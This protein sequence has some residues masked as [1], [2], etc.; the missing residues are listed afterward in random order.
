MLN[1]QDTR[2]S[3][4]VSS[5]FQLILFFDLFF[6]CICTALFQETPTIRSFLPVGESFK[7]NQS[8][9]LFIWIWS[10]HPTPSFRAPECRNVGGLHLGSGIS[11]LRK[12]ACIYAMVLRQGNVM[13]TGTPNRRGY[14]CQSGR[15]FRKFL[16]KCSSSGSFFVNFYTLFF[17]TT[18][19]ILL[20]N[21]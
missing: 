1:L 21:V 20:R 16:V 13:E 14:E 11:R 6:P 12:Y 9:N 18:S 5:P 15:T 10:F 8:I 3:Q 2:L 19:S 4:D 7:N 17:S